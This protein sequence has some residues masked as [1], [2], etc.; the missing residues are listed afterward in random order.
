[1][2]YPGPLQKQK[3]EKVAVAMPETGTTCFYTHHLV[4]GAVEGVVLREDEKDD[5]G[6]VDVM[7]IS[8]L[9]VVKDLED[10]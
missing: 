9:H 5:E 2:I 4:D 7:R 8:V 6:H 10:G 3:R 1:M